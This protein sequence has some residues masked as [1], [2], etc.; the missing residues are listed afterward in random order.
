MVIYGRSCMTHKEEKPGGIVNR[1]EDRKGSV[2]E[3]VMVKYWWR[4][5][6]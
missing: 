2:V 5:V 4:C 6:L 3:D 1:G